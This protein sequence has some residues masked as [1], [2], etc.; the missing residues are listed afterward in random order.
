MASH[1][2]DI[3]T[4]P[5]KAPVNIRHARIGSPDQVFVLYGFRERLVEGRTELIQP[6]EIRVVVA[7]HPI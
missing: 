1:R 2:A 4:I 7:H 6:S 3:G 5:R